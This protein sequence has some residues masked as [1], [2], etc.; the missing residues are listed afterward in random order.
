MSLLEI[1]ATAVTDKLKGKDASVCI[2]HGGYELRKGPDASF[3]S[4][5][6]QNDPS[7]VS[8]GPAAIGMCCP[9]TRKAPQAGRAHVPVGGAK[10]GSH[11]CPEANVACSAALCPVLCIFQ[12]HVCMMDKLHPRGTWQ[13]FCSPHNTGKEAN[14]A[15]RELKVRWP[16]SEAAVPPSKQP[17]CC[18]TLLASP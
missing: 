7:R 16:R 18:Q 6:T 3:I 1:Q 2:S 12:T 4:C 13:P 8:V 11:C 5:W 15:D 14:V 17:T 10:E 9:R